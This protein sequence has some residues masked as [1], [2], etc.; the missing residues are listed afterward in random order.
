MLEC[1]SVA[2]Y[3]R[4]L[5]RL[6]PVPDSVACCCISDGDTVLSLDSWTIVVVLWLVPWIDWDVFR[7]SFLASTTS[8]R[9]TVAHCWPE[10]VFV[11]LH[12]CR[13]VECLVWLA[14]GMWLLGDSEA[15]S[16]ECLWNLF[17]F[18][19]VGFCCC[20]CPLPACKS[21]PGR[22]LRSVFGRTEPVSWRAT[23]PLCNS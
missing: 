1:E 2:C 14:A 5:S 4:C 3:S 22:G 8:Y 17:G 23:S 18:Q 6:V 11:K 13:A 20:V 21:I 9:S 16:I 12:G 10:N 19:T 15:M 7:L